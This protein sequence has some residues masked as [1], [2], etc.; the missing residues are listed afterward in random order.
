VRSRGEKLLAEL[1]AVRLG[2]AGRAWTVVLEE[3][4]SSSEGSGWSVGSAR[5]A[6][7]S[8]A[9]A[10]SVVAAAAVAADAPEAEKSG[11]GLPECEKI[12]HPARKDS[13]LVV[14]IQTRSP[15]FNGFIIKSSFRFLVISAAAA[16]IDLAVVVDGN[17]SAPLQFLHDLLVGLNRLVVLLDLRVG[18]LDLLVS[19]V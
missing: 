4:R 15:I 6:A 10:P 7:L 17:D 5:V 13:R 12:A 8:G 11:A 3:A 14:A 9:M 18:L 19:R 1:L 16:Q 2:R